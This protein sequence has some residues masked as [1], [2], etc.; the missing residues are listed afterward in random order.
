MGNNDNKPKKTEVV[1][2]INSI[3]LLKSQ[4]DLSKIKIKYIIKIIFK[5]IK[6]KKKLLIL[7][8]NNKAKN[9]LDIDISNYQN[10]AGENSSI[11]LEIKPLHIK[12]EKIINI[13]NDEDRLYY[14]IYFNNNENVEIKKIF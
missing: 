8:L 2:Q 12:S 6:I 1:N 3:N 14:H 10:Y 4:G 9:R 7:K 11:E 13:F 5:Y